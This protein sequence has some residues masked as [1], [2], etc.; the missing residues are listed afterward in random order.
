MSFTEA[1]E[2]IQHAHLTKSDRLDLSRLALTRVPAEITQLT[3]LTTLDISRNQLPRV[4]AE[5]TQLTNLTTLD[6]SGN[7][8]KNIRADFRRLT[9]LT[10]VNFSGN[11]I[12][13]IRAD[14]GRLTNLTTVDLGSNLLTEIPPELGELVELTSLDISY[15]L[16]TEIPSELVQL[17]KLANLDLTGNSSLGIPVEVGSGRPADLLRYILDSQEGASPLNEVKLL[18]LGR[19][20]AGKTS[21]RDRLIRDKFY[22]DRNETVGI[23][24]EAWSRQIDGEHIR[25]NVWDFAGQEIAHATHRFFL[26]ERSVYVV[27]LDA[28]ADTQD[29]DAA[30]WLR[31]VAAYGGASPILVVLNKIDEK[32][33]DVDENYL[34]RQFPSIGGFIKTDCATRT[35]LDDLAAA[36]DDAI[37]NR[38]T[39]HDMFPDTWHRLKEHFA[40]LDELPNYQ[41]LTEFR[42]RCTRL[43]ETDPERQAG[44]ARTLHAL[45]LIVHYADDPRLRDTTVLNPQWV[46]HAVYSLL[47]GGERPQA[48]GLLDLGEARRILPDEPEEQVLYL[49]NLMRRFDLC[50]PVAE[51]QSWLVPELLPKFQPKL[52]AE[53]DER[54]GVRVRYRY[55][56]F[57][58]GLITQLMARLYP[59]LDDVGHWRYGAT[60]SMDGAQALARGSNRD[61]LVEIT[62]IGPEEQRLRLIKLIRRQFESIHEAIPGLIVIDELKMAGQAEAYT[63]VKTLE[64]DESKGGTTTVATDA[65]SI[66]I[67]QAVQLDQISSRLTRGRQPSPLRLFLS[68]SHQDTSMRDRIRMNLDLL[69]YDKYIESWDD[70]RIVPSS[71]WDSEIRSE[72]D[73]AD[74]IVMLVSTPFL[75]SNYVQ[76]VEMP[77]ALE[78]REAGE[79][80]LVSVILERCSWKSRPLAKFQVVQPD[81][82]PVS[83]WKNRREAFYVVESELRRLIDGRRSTVD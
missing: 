40:Q 2:R 23:D 79:A 43:G 15:N 25:L 38:T 14:F 55:S 3:N 75:T 9:E 4:P 46:T 65:G 48:D 27:V 20:G 67:D 52:T 32:P 53:F 18:L 11:E 54:S 63:S 16:L 47:R 37:S 1:Q 71:E 56:I 36:I 77:R 12:A 5:I 8:L 41:S 57:P 42:H 74:I 72:L 29:D 39:V 66:I 68:Y 6:I 19:G 24:I 7:L 76:T 45:G 49:M 81:G 13:E 60:F 61:R 44:L 78:R 33:F 30:Y 50:F 69:T 83:G 10:S 31:T 22:P 59:L 64:I 28:R 34:L 70:G 17:T 58:E 73:A 26:T 62:A 82:K 51:D 21:I 35:G 80:D